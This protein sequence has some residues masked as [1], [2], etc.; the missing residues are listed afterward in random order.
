MSLI[1]KSKLFNLPRE[2]QLN[3]ERYYVS[4]YK[5]AHLPAKRKLEENKTGGLLKIVFHI[6]KNFIN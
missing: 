5:L 3:F 1:L 2:L 4:G 6:L